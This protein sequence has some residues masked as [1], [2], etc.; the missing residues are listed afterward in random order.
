MKTT[1]AWTKG[2]FGTTC[3]IYSGDK[4]VGELKERSL[5]LKAY[6]NLNNKQYLFVT[7]GIL[8]RTTEII[9]VETEHTIGAITYNTWHTKAK[10]SAF[11]EVYNWKY[12][13]IWN[14]RWSLY[15]H[16]KLLISSKRSATEGS[17]ELGEIEE[18]LVLSSLF[19]M[20][21]Y[22]HYT[23]VFAALIP[24]FIVLFT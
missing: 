7:K 3:Q 8:R 12:N 2:F 1:L 23:A 9:D 15:E 21:N 20:N 5:S 14:T 22:R 13:N 4:K 11:A 6:G 10:I 19:V 24:I 17:L 16:G 18:S